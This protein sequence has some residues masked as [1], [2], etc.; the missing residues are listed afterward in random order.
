MSSQLTLFSPV[1]SSGLPLPISAKCKKC[2][3]NWIGNDAISAPSLLGCLCFWCHGEL[4][5]HRGER[6]LIKADTHEETRMGK[7]WENYLRIEAICNNGRIPT[8]RL[9]YVSRDG[10]GGKSV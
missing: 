6:D 8:G 7:A 9:E 10:Y 4:R 3:Y 2:G 1:E 5:A